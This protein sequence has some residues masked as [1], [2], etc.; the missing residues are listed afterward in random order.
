MALH[1]IRIFCKLLLV[2]LFVYFFLV[3]IGLM[4]SAFKG[5]GKDFA[6]K[7]I[8]T[9]S[10]PFI[11]LFIG[12]LATSI[13]Q[14][15]STIT[16]IVVGMVASGVMTIT[17][18]VPII[19]GANIGTTVT[20]M[21]V[22][23][24]HIGRR[25]E[26]KRAVSGSA[27]HDFFNIMCVCLLFPLEV[28]FHILSNTAKLM[29]GIFANVGGIKFTSPL[30][31]ATEPPIE[32]IETILG[33]MVAS[34]KLMHTLLLILSMAILFTSLYFIVRLMRT[35]IVQRAEIVFNNVLGRHGVLT[36]LAG[37]AVTAIVQSSSITTSLMVPL[38]A[39]GILTV[40]MVFPITMGANIGTTVTAIL[41]SFATGNVAAITVAFTHFLFNAI[42]VCC[43][44]PIKPMRKIPIFLA[45]K[46]GDIA[47]IRRRYVV[48]Y[49]ITVF[50]ILPA[51]LITI[52]KIAR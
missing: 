45:K 38:V 5:F 19:M 11:G 33:R 15:S 7:L 13:V 16:S 39:A 30:K 42:G 52:S 23:L 46:L 51:L 6:E 20:S 47:F 31:L 1:R 49:V 17:N 9:T 28:F 36:L 26:F 35:I 10:N 18:A 21:M 41:A 37:I 32:F 8:K 50:F 3:S 4:G 43:I 44:Y 25:E 40:E 34:E 29:S 27:V 12:I 48:I 22:S 24:G 14:S 2:F